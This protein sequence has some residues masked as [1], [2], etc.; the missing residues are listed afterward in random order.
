[1]TYTKSFKFKAAPNHLLVEKQQVV[2]EINFTALP[3]CVCQISKPNEDFAPLIQ[4][5]DVKLSR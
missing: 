3:I 5:S 1:M 2:S 4:F